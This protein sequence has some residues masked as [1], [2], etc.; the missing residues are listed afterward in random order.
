MS[1]TYMV[2]AVHQGDDDMYPENSVAKTSRHKR[3][4]PWLS[5]VQPDGG[6]FHLELPPGVETKLT[7][8]S[9]SDE[10]SVSSLAL[11][12]GGC[13]S[14]DTGYSSDQDGPASSADKSDC[15]NVVR[16]GKR[17]KHRSRKEDLTSKTDTG[18]IPQP[19]SEKNFRKSFSSLSSSG[20]TS[21]IQ[22]AEA[23][24]DQLSLS[25]SG[26]VSGKHGLSSTPNH[27]C[28]D[29]VFKSSLDDEDDGICLNKSDLRSSK[30]SSVSGF[31]YQSA[32]S[33]LSSD[34]RG[35]TSMHRRSNENSFSSHSSHSSKP[36]LNNSHRTKGS[37]TSRSSFSQKFKNPLQW[38]T[39]HVDVSL[40]TQGFLKSAKAQNSAL[41][42]SESKGQDRMD[43]C[44]NLLG[45][46]P[47]WPEDVD[48]SHSGHT[49]VEVMVESVVPGS[50]VSCSSHDL[51][52]AWLHRVN[53]HILTWDNM[54]TILASLGRLKK[55]KLTFKSQRS[56]KS[57]V[58]LEALVNIL[59]TDAQDD[60][61]L[62]SMAAM[63]I[64]LDGVDPD[65]P[66]S[67]A[68][69]GVVYSFPSQKNPLCH[70]QGLF[71]TLAHLVKDMSMRGTIRNTTIVV[72]KH[73]IHVAY[74][75]EGSD[76]LV[77][78]V[79]AAYLS[80][81]QLNALLVEFS[82]LLRLLFVSVEAAFTGAESTTFIDTILSYLFRQVVAAST[83]SPLSPSSTS[84]FSAS[85]SLTGYDDKGENNAHT[86]SQPFVRFSQH[87]PAM[88]LPADISIII[89]RTMSEFESSDFADM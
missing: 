55:A 45:I 87:I 58:D 18:S 60:Y 11:G 56:E 8:L 68:N 28:A 4:P 20:S 26:L 43:L 50:P 71:Y 36:Y 25:S 12:V 5:S 62:D 6:L 81:P 54:H 61:C 9:S 88:A 35:R 3:A 27:F 67:S 70:L 41:Y 53:G 22:E 30:T 46:L 7:R 1:I 89:D 65:D 59:T 49:D 19:L 40:P 64:S 69:D 57:S 85:L 80:V 23:Q 73:T 77:F 72:D 33:V 2:F 39:F 75:Q 14:E 78:A 38:K 32:S 13:N 16:P 83:S 17:S 24:F 21:T 52:G 44:R 79:P 74:L 86:E 29:G 10:G 15:A 42:L 63:Y 48:P 76:I 31:S 51:Q 82:R 37:N 47:T 34:S 84:L 66:S